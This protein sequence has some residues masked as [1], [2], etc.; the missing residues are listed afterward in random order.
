MI[1][2]YTSVTDMAGEFCFPSIIY[3]AIPGRRGKSTSIKL[4]L[5]SSNL[6]NET[7]SMII[8]IYHIYD[9]MRIM[10]PAMIA[11]RY[12]SQVL[13]NKMPIKRPL[14]RRVDRPKVARAPIV[15]IT[16]GAARAVGIVL[17]AI[18]PEILSYENNRCK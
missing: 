7:V 13:M 3:I 6:M 15:L 2:N 18:K 9:E 1:N 14:V 10:L 4:N 11:P 5:F 16:N 8:C 17:K 12:M